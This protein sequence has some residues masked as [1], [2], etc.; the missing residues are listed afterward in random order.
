MFYKWVEI[1]SKH[2]K[3]FSIA[4]IREFE[5]HPNDELTK[6]EIF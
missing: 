1:L 4:N 3:I 5:A 2:L 6:V